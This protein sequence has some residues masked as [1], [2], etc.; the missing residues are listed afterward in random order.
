MLELLLVV[1]T[2]LSRQYSGLHDMY[3]QYQ[4]LLEGHS[5]HVPQNKRLYEP[6]SNTNAPIR[7]HP[8]RIKTSSIVIDSLTC[9]IRLPSPP[10]VL[11]DVLQGPSPCLRS[12][13]G[14]IP[15]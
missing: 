7:S 3:K 2:M 12:L 5:L 13:L 10:L 15:A 14:Q 9:L 4:E 8:N 11:A 1:V 6:H